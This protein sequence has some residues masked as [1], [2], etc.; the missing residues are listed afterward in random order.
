[1]STFIVVRVQGSAS[2]THA[3]AS[4]E[5]A[6]ALAQPDAGALLEWAQIEAD[7][8]GAARSSV[9]RWR[10]LQLCE[11]CDDAD[12]LFVRATETVQL[13]SSGALARVCADCARDGESDGLCLRSTEAR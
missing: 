11:V 1:M 2:D 9:V 7:D 3:A 13:A 6:L 10:A 12:G 4:L 8:A 5:G